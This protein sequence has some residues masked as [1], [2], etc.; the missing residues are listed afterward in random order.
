MF[1]HVSLLGSAYGS[2][3]LFGFARNHSGARRGLRVHSCSRGFTRARIEV[4]GFICV[5]LDSLRVRRMR[6]LGFTRVRLG[7]ALF[8]RVAWVHSGAHR[9]RWVHSGSRGF[10]RARVGVSWFILVGVGSLGRA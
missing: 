2:P 6:S 5:R 1:I 3:G 9:C 4:F 7:V 8:N 10:I